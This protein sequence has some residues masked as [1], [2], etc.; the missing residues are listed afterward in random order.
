M[1]APDT[2]FII[3][4]V[5]SG[6]RDIESPI[7]EHRWNGTIARVNEIWLVIYPCYCEESPSRATVKAPAWLLITRG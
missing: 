6:M 3:K 7:I 2:T 5:K 4:A 1:T